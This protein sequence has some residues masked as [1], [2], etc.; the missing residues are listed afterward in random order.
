MKIDHNLIDTLLYG[1]EGIDLD[2]KI[3]QYKFTKAS[4]DE[5]GELLKD[6]LAFA[7][8]WRRSDAFILIGVKEIKS[9]KSEI[10]GIN[11]KLDDAQIQQFV[12]SKTQKPLTFSYRNMDFAG[13]CI[14]II[15]IPIQNRP[16]YLKN[17]FGK[18]KKETVYI[19]RGSS[20][21]SAKPD[22]IAIMGK[23]SSTIKESQPI[24]EVFFADKKNRI[25]LSDG[26]PIKSL[27]LNTPRIND[28][29]DYDGDSKLQKS[30]FDLSLE[31]PN[32]DYY[33]KLTHFTTLFRLLTPIN[34]AIQNTGSTVAKD[35]RLKIK[36]QDDQNIIKALDEY[37]MPTIPKSSYSR[38]NDLNFQFPNTGT[39]HDLTVKR[40]SDYWLIEAAVEKVQSK[41]IAWLDSKLFIGSIKTVDF[42]METSIFSDNLSEPTTKNLL[43][44]V[45]STSKSV[46]LN[47]ILELERE[48][49]LN[50]PE[51]HEF[52]KKHSDKID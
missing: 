20:T 45:E 35:V 10:V 42:Y 48:R 4:D 9:D 32:Y 49:F 44:K 1:E 12:N 39:P 41:S 38:F 22:E 27:I 17:D 30:Y 23:P 14:G 52:A 25:I 26:F 8:S 2:F 16:L 34:F 5:K 40:I 50:S 21:D 46:G 6:I 15:H 31:R 24:L 47:E 11:E 3:D 7:N 36:I 13:K 18:L 37:D 33:R 51:Y 28:I 29:P 43:I 19:R